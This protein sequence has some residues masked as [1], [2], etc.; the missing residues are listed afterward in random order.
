MRRSGFTLPNYGQLNYL[1]SISLSNRGLQ[2]YLELPIRLLHRVES[3]N[4]SGLWGR[5]EAS[6]GHA[7]PAR[8]DV[9]EIT[10][11]LPAQSSVQVIDVRH[12]AHGN[13]QIAQCLLCQKVSKSSPLLLENWTQVFIVG[14]GFVASAGPS[15]VVDEQIVLYLYESAFIPVNE[16]APNRYLQFLLRPAEGKLN[17]YHSPGRRRNGNGWANLHPGVIIS[18]ATPK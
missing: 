4:R 6:R 12:L 7:R 10:E 9:R 18:N 14:V 16:P 11:R 5:Q 3:T 15:P 8:E 2:G 13:H 1:L 17:A